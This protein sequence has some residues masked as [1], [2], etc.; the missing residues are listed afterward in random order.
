VHNLSW[1]PIEGYSL[2]FAALPAAIAMI[3]DSFLNF[4]DDEAG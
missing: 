1:W 4:K 3:A 2:T